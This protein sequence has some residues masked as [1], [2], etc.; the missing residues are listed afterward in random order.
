MSTRKKGGKPRKRLEFSLPLWDI[1]KCFKDNSMVMIKIHRANRK[2]SQ[3]SIPKVSSRKNVPLRLKIIFIFL[4]LLV[5]SSGAVIYTDTPLFYYGVIALGL[6]IITIL[7][8]FG[9]YLARGKQ[10]L[11]AASETNEMDDNEEHS[12]GL[13]KVL[14]AERL[15]KDKAVK[16]STLKK[17]QIKKQP[18]KRKKHRRIG[19]ISL[20]ES[21]FIKRQKISGREGNSESL[22][23]SRDSRGSKISKK[24]KKTSKVTTFLCPSCGSKELYYEAGLISGY[25]YHCKDC[26]YIGSFVIEKDFEV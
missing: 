2:S 16:G 25:K 19:S 18:E 8:Y 3:V 4:V 17:R 1:F 12:V 7:V 6:V 15:Y 10:E 9:Y 22:K 14:K 21:M 13:E 20:E 23:G 26:D 5:M 11:F 24:A